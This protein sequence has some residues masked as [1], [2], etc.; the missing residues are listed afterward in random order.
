MVFLKEGD[1]TIALSGGAG[2][3]D[4]LRSGTDA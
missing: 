2:S 3:N 1:L 4:C